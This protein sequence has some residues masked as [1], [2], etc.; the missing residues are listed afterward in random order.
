MKNNFFL[1]FGIE[2]MLQGG[3]QPL[4]S[5]FLSVCIGILPI[6][7]GDAATKR[8]STEY[9]CDKMLFNKYI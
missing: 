2:I 3:R 1:Y 6:M 7:A 5:L 8:P 9:K 4:P